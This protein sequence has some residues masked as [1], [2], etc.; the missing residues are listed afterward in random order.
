ME[1]TTIVAVGDGAG[2]GVEVTVGSGEGEGS[3]VGVSVGSAVAVG[4]TGVSVGSGNEVGEGTWATAVTSRLAVGVTSLASR[5][6][7][8]ALL[9]LIRQ[10]R[11]VMNVIPLI[12]FFM[13]VASASYATNYLEFDQDANL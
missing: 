9:Q 12:E 4:G 11:S 10:T 3:L 7:S 2:E 8:A 5:G 6:V 13:A 1:S